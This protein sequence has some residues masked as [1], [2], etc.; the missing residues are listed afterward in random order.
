MGLK[1]ERQKT[2]VKRCPGSVPNPCDFKSFTDFPATKGLRGLAER[3]CNATKGF[4][5]WR[6]GFARRSRTN[7]R[8]LRDLMFVAKRTDVGKWS[9]RDQCL[10]GTSW[11]LSGNDRNSFFRQQLRQRQVFRCGDFQ[12][13]FLAGDEV[14]GIAGTFPNGSFIGE[15]RLERLPESGF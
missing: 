13:S 10:S 8:S 14:N 3:Y 1:V 11:L 12:V 9:R 6:N 7:I 15:R 5:D 4:A 2:I